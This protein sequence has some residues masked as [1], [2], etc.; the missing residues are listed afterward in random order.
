MT[1][2]QDLLWLSH[3]WMFS[4]W[5]VSNAICWSCLFSG[6]SVFLLEEAL[7]V[8]PGDTSKTPSTLWSQNFF[9]SKDEVTDPS[10]AK[11]WERYLN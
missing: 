8:T 11:F 9:P 1:D 10:V 2:L 3:K 5:R 6:E 4:L 7:V